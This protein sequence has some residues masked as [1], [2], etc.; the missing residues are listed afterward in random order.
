MRT[1]QRRA[2][3]QM[4]LFILCGIA[5]AIAPAATIPLWFAFAAWSLAEVLRLWPERRR[6]GG[7]MRWQ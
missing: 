3:R 7:Y 2:I 5:S 4:I 6:V 1:K